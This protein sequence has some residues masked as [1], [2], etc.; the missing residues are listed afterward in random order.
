MRLIKRQTTNNRSIIGNGIKYNPDS[1]ITTIPGQSILSP[2]GTTDDRPTGVDGYLRFNTDY[3]KLEY[4]YDN[5]WRFV[6]SGGADGAIVTQTLYSGFNKFDKLFGPLDAKDAAY[7][8]NP[9]TDRTL[10]FVEQLYQAPFVDYTISENPIE[11]GI[12]GEV[13]PH[14]IV[15]GKEYMILDAGTT[16]FTAFGSSNNDLHTIF[17]ANY[18]VSTSTEITITNPVA[19]AESQFGYDVDAS[20]TYIVVGCPKE[21][22]SAIITDSGSTYIFNHAGNQIYKVI[23]PTSYG[24]ANNDHFG[25]AVAINESTY[26]AVGCYREDTA[27][28]TG[29]MSGRVHIYDLNSM[30]GAPS[31][32]LTNPNA[33]GVNE[34][35]WFGYDVDLSES[36]LIV[37]APNADGLSGTEGKAYIYA[38]DNLA[39]GPIILNNP[40]GVGSGT[41][42]NFGK[43][44]AINE[45]YAMV[46]SHNDTVYIFDVETGDLLHTLTGSQDGLDEKFGH[47]L[48][49]SNDYLIVGA[50]DADGETGNTKSGRAYVYHITGPVPNEPLYT[51]INPN[52]YLP[53]TEDQFGYRVSISDT[54]A[55]VTSHNEDEAGV[56]NTGRAYVYDIADGSMVTHI[57]NPNASGTG[58][59]DNYGTAVAVTLNKVIAGAHSEDNGAT[60]GTGTVYSTQIDG[61][62][63]GTGV[64]RETGSYVMFT[65]SLNIAPVTKTRQEDGEVQINFDFAVNNL[66]I[67]LV[68][69]VQTELLGV[70][71]SDKWTFARTINVNGDALGNVTI[72]GT[73][74]VT[75]TLQVIADSHTHDYRHALVS[76]NLAEPF[77]ASSFQLQDWNITKENNDIIFV[78]NGT[79]VA[80]IGSDGTIG[81]INNVV[82]NTTI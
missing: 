5:S 54:Y 17:T 42:L 73:Q 9:A 69:N 63:T 27:T 44:V 49:V 7:F 72:D 82:G 80:K 59:D 13:L 28:S 21:D 45:H 35:D 15:N 14:K 40:L 10:V 39:N 30:T 6:G 32:S 2:S 31:T 38:L 64:C 78:Y 60:L 23:N 79:K 46:S 65:N 26:F 57:L 43:A 29:N 81:A 34:E 66:K 22:E 67:T 19:E 74:D 71:Q 56:T 53:D 4:Y 1:G 16:P 76:G 75:L 37:G 48:D 62:P 47:S 11:R 20:E 50:P 51:L 41:P 18:T 70:S 58:D 77:A 12:G 52:L 36:Y 68:Y 61:K 25:S 33:G 24:T 55:V 8:V 3:G